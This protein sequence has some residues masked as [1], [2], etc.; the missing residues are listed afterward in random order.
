MYKYF[1]GN[2]SNL[3]TKS[4][5]EPIVINVSNEVMQII[6]IWLDSYE[7]DLDS[8]VEA[9]IFVT[10]S[11]IEQIE[12]NEDEELE[13]T[14]NNNKN[15]ILKLLG[16]KEPKIEIGIELMNYTIIII[17]NG[18]EIESFVEA[19]D[20]EI[21][22][23]VDFLNNAVLMG[24]EKVY[25]RYVFEEFDMSIFETM[26]EN[27]QKLDIWDNIAHNMVWIREL[28]VTIPSYELTITYL[29]ETGLYITKI[30]VIHNQIFSYILSN[31]SGNYEIEKDGNWN[32]EHDIFKYRYNVWNDKYTLGIP[33]GIRI[34]T[35]YYNKCFAY[36][37]DFIK[38]M[39]LS[40]NIINSEF[41][42]V[43]KAKA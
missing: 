18:F 23:G 36:V 20:D 12:L 21:T 3:Q 15:A 14:F 32:A 19:I 27:I 13:M 38:M 4:E 43:D 9:I 25:S 34:S 8:L 10:E 17:Q 22:M 2:R 6:N 29:E 11:E 1:L 39:F 37:K 35:Q 33:K 30:C 41:E 28:P 31:S 7:L 5:G 40:L 16:E 26:K 42:K 24:K